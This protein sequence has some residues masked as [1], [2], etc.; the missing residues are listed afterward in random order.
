MK[1]YVKYHTKRLLAVGAVSLAI[2]GLS[3]GIA[4]TMHP[5][6]SAARSQ[7]TSANDGETKG[8]ATKTPTPHIQDNGQDGE[9]TD[10]AS[11]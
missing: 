8:D 1:L 4:F 11:Q 5:S 9:T 7:T 2:V 6:A 10:S 3:A